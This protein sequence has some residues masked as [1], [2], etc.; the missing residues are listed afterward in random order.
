MHA[1]LYMQCQ[2]AQLVVL[3]NT[4]SYTVSIQAIPVHIL[5]SIFPV[6][7]QYTSLSLLSCSVLLS[8]L[9]FS[10]A[11]PF[12]ELNFYTKQI[13]SSVTLVNLLYIFAESK[14]FS[15]FSKLG[16]YFPHQVDSKNGKAQW[17]ADKNI[18]TVTARMI[19]EYDC[20]NID[21]R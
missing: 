9:E 10:R 2:P 5:H 21:S 15:V 14:L 7:F 12:T 11:D 18:L 20:L 17:D 19:R 6:L 3:V 1:S 8:Q 16:L 4:A 13:I